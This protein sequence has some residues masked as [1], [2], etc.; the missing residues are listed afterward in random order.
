MS[1]ATIILQYV[2]AASAIFAGTGLLLNY[3]AFRK[4]QKN[5]QVKLLEEFS[6]RYFVLIDKQEEYRKQNK[7]GQFS[8]LFLNHLEWFAY[9]VNNKYLPFKMAE[10]YEGIIINWY[11]KAL[12][13]QGDVLK[14]YYE[15]QSKGF[16]ELDKLYQRFKKQKDQ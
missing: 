3:C 7:I 1:I 2:S 10:I 4:Q 9:L 8:V 11:E 6:S 5:L 13:K 16:S 14:E 15:A 12:L